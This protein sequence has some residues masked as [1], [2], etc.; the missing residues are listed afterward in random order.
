MQT[1]KVKQELSELI[2]QA[3]VRLEASGDVPAGTTE[4]PIQI[5]RTRQKTHGDFATNVSLALAKKAGK[6]PRELAAEVIE[7]LADHPGV[8]KVEIAGPGFIN[9]F[10]DES[11]TLA[12]IKDV[13][14]R[15][16]HYG[17]VNIGNGDLITV[18]FVSANPTGP[19][20]VGHGRGA[21]FG[22]SLSRLLEVA[23]YQVHR[24]YYFN[25]AGRQMD[26]LALSVWLRYLDQLG[27]E[28]EFPG[29]AYQ[30]EYIKD[31]AA[32]LAVK[33]GNDFNMM[34]DGFFVSG[35]EQDQEAHLDQLI[36]N[37]RQ[38]LGQEAKEQVL[39][40]V[41]ATQVEQIQDD[42]H[43]F[44]VD[45]DEW[46]SEG[47]LERSGAIA[48]AIAIL[49]ENGHIYEQDGALWFRASDFGDDKDRVVIRKN[50]RHT[51]FAAD[52]AYMVNK[53]DRGFKKLIYIW[54][55]DHH[56]TV[57]R[58]HAAFQAFGYDSDQF[59]ILLVQMASLY[60]GGER[61]SMSTR[62][63]EFVTLEEL[64]EEVGVD[65]ARFFYSMR[66]NEQQMDF[67][68]DLA[69][70]QSN[71]NPVYY[72]QYA[73]ARVCSIFRQAEEQQITVNEIEQVDLSF[74]NEEIEKD[75]ARKLEVFPE[76]ITLA[77]RDFA[78]HQVTYYLRELAAAFHSYYNQVKI[79]N[80]DDQTRQAR[81]ALISAVRQVLQN[82]LAII[83]VSAPKYM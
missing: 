32:S 40:L 15:G 27:V 3:L 14:S 41:L 6:N 4:L 67:D 75:L 63:A 78:P 80:A 31:I 74:L 33:Y 83:G 81:L 19:L 51:Y 22:D 11:Q 45:F 18:E 5:E 52:I 42:L 28:V 77:A 26:I 16:D 24:E 65:A 43:E 21:A 12:S 64:R 76:M 35:V 56:G 48:R 25:D 29:N 59:V 54:G 49:K 10:V 38:S 61:V 8:N 2:Q 50:G 1:S 34:I 58:V 36:E 30:G 82:G 55:A 73:H 53:I 57:A 39:N 23:G 17:Q 62:R 72:V 46:F 44:G 37:M 68:L 13:L 20:H 69:K 66:K 47:S 79:L 9:F 71:D 60:R 70:S 7:V